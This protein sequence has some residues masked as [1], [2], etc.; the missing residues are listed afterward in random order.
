MATFHKYSIGDRVEDRQS[1]ELGIVVHVYKEPELDHELVR[2]DGTTA[3]ASL[4]PSTST[5]SDPK[6]D[7][8][9]GGHDRR[10]HLHRSRH[11]AGSDVSR[12][13]LRRMRGLLFEAAMT[14][15]SLFA[16]F[17][18]AALLWLAAVAVCVLIASRQP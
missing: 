17:I 15:V 13:R 9:G 10:F 11:A 12:Y 6:C 3:T 1:R 16:I 7:G 5:T 18:A 14:E 8:D 4:S 2:F